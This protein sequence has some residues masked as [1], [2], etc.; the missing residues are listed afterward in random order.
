MGP[1]FVWLASSDVGKLRHVSDTSDGR[2]L[3]L[4]AAAAPP[5]R[6]VLRL[7]TA[8][9]LPPSVR[10]TEPLRC[11]GAETGA[12][13]EGVVELVSRMAERAFRFEAPLAPGLLALVLEVLL[14]F[15]FFVM[16]SI[17]GESENLFWGVR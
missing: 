11:L 7:T 13:E 1:R 5:R 12:T 10:L 3:L 4:V 8:L 15:L 9:F 6:E 16:L 2:E 14:R 17:D